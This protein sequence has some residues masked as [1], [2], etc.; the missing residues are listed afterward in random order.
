MHDLIRL[1]FISKYLYVYI[2][3]NIVYHLYHKS[4]YF[5][6]KIKIFDMII[7][8]NK[9]AQSTFSIKN[10]YKALKGVLFIFKSGFQFNILRMG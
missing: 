7:I 8:I 5:H 10:V 3:N 2:L 1:E 6:K 9:F 4:T